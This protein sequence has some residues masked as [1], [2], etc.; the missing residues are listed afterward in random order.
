MEEIDINYLNCHIWIEAELWKEGSWDCNDCNTDVIVVFPDRSKWIASFFTYC[1]IET[2]RL[3]N[4]Q[5]GECMHGSYFWSSDMVLIDVISRE[6]IEQLIEHLIKNEHF[7]SVFNRYPDVDKEEAENYPAGYFI[8]DEPDKLPRY[9]VTKEAIE[10]LTK[11]LNLMKLPEYSQDW[12]IEAA[13]LSRV[14]EFINYY[15]SLTTRL[16]GDEKFA[17]MKLILSSFDD[18][19]S[20]GEGNKELWF[21]I[22]DHLIKDLDMFRETIRYWALIDEDFEEGFELTPYMRELVVE[23]SL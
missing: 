7:Q 9:F 2:L 1:N 14:T 10:S 20:G 13:E 22:K 21:R 17:L 4:S 8:I 16:N 3:K 15:D 6:R 12:E 18:A 11:Q 5:T 23:F 19:L